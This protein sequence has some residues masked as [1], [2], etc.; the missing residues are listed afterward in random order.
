MRALRIARHI[1][2]AVAIIVTIPL[3][4]VPAAAQG[5]G[6]LSG[7]VL[8]AAGS[9][10]EGATVLAVPAGGG[11]GRRARTDAAGAWRI[12]R[13]PAGA[14][15]VRATRL[16]FASAEREASVAAGGET[17][18]ELRLTEESV[19]LDPLEATSRRDTERERTRFETEGGVTARV[20]T[21]AELKVLPGLGEADVMRAVEVLP[22]VVSTSDFSSA[23]HVR[24]GSAD[25]NLI[26]LDGFP[27][28]NPFHLGGLFS[29]F[30]SD[31][32]ARAE[33]LAGGFGAEYGGRVSSVL[34]VE[35][36]PGGEGEGIGVDAGVSL[37]A[38]RVAVN[39]NLPGAIPRALG[40]TEGSWLVSARRS[41]FDIVLKPVIDFPYHL[42]DIQGSAT[43]GVGGGGRLRF[44]GYTGEDVLDFSEF[45]PP[46]LDDDEDSILRIFWNWG[47][48]VAGV[49]WEQPWGAWV[50]ST[51]LGYSRYAESLG[52]VEYDDTRFLSRVDLLALKADAGRSLGS[53]LTVRLGGEASRMS[54]RNLGEAGGTT[55]FEGRGDGVLTAAYGQLRWQPGAWIV[56]PGLRA[57]AWHAGTTR[58]HLSP[59][60]AV[61]RFFGAGRD[62]AV[63]LAAGRYVQFLH[64]LRDESL[65]IANDNWIT[66]D[67][68]VPALVSD[69]VQLGIEKYWGERWYASV[70][71]YWRGYEG[72][73]DL[74][75]ADDPN[76]DTDD[77]LEGDGWSYGVDLMVRRSTGK[78]TGWATLSLLKAQRTFPDPLAQGI[79][80]VPQETT[81]PPVFDRRVDLDLVMQY[82]LPGRID[83]GLRL[84]YGSGVPYTRPTAAFVGFE[85]DVIQGGYRVPR[86]VGDDPEIPLYI[87][88]GDRN[89][90]RYPA[91]QRLDLTFRRTYRPRWGT[92]TPYLQVLNATNKRNVL[93]Y[94]YD[95]DKTPATRSGISMFP[96]LPAFGFEATF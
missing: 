70:E 81:F 6:T 12:A 36:K 95:Y 80:G 37:L 19:L 1:A 47:N 75:V 67:E 53:E 24:G 44:V 11:E 48:D 34:A 50:T 45:D 17:R 56:E 87:V 55:F 33:L 8:G 40:G 10:V 54:Y 69:Q 52:F 42:T 31:A 73:T 77:L 46:G 79:D 64:S 63:K 94:F 32:V 72:V 62:G 90:E 22:G 88:P 84:N 59:R 16:G 86:P 30:N 27:I 29:V 20:I 68:N 57:D 83:A 14:Y 5:A 15:R 38:S 65:P 2:A 3:F 7:R 61:K 9:P 43:I 41:Y 51:S 28:F 91:Y 4:A 71:G 96:T 21:G 35:T 39:G 82:R 78:L 93:F 26:L 13:L 60:L 85:T 49:R 23:F 58:A 76:D 66:S 89:R 25:Q 92:F 74:N 18:L